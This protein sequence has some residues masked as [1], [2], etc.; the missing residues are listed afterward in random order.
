MC[1][2]QHRWEN[3][4][5]ACRACNG[6]QDERTLA[7]VGW[8]LSLKPY[9]PKATLY[10]VFRHEQQEPATVPIAELGDCPLV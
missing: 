3:V 1:S 6:H 8:A 5:A 9:A 4:V 10:V 7:Q 2:G